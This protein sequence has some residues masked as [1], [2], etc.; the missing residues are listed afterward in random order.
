MVGFSI[1]QH[2]NFLCEF[3]ALSKSDYE[4][5]GWKGKSWG[6]KGASRDLAVSANLSLVSSRLSEIVISFAVLLVTMSS[7]PK[8]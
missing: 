5:L 4:E 7:L 8:V 6:Q 3:F 2:L 1:D